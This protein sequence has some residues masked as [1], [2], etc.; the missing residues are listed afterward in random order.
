MRHHPDALM[1]FAAGF[2]TRMGPLT[3]DRPKPMVEV[4]GK[5]LIDHARAIA[6][7][8][9]IGR[10]VANLHYKPEPLIEH[11]NGTGILLSHERDTLLDTGG[12]LRKA[13]PLLGPGPV[14]TL[15]SDAVWTGANPLGELRS[16]WDP[17]R[18]DALLLLLDPHDARGHPGAGDFTLS[19]GRLNRGPGYV[20]SG[21]QIIKTESLHD[22]AEAV[23]SLNLIWDR[24]IGAGRLSGIVHQGEWCDVG[25]PQGIAEAEALLD[26]DRD[27]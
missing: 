23:F 19:D 25:H 22:V 4:A 12:G 17:D 6:E 20:Y 8:A 21:A 13:L 5:P 10:I 16:A 2:G 26:Y 14:F 7:D 11:L 1:I 15:N 27:V 9:G 24:M 3:A 18:M